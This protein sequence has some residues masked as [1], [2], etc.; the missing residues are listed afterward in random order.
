[1]AEKY[2]IVSIDHDDFD[3]EISRRHLDPGCCFQ[4]LTHTEALATVARNQRWG[5]VPEVVLTAAWSTA[6]RPARKER[7][8]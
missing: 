4:C 3:N 2:L 7:A 8:A 5:I 6:N 1:M